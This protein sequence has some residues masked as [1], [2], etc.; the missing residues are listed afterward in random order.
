VQTFTVQ[1]AFK[2]DYPVQKV[3]KA[4]QKL[5]KTP[6]L[7]GWIIDESKS[8]RIIDKIAQAY[9]RQVEMLAPLINKVA[10]DVPKRRMRKLHIGLFGYSRKVGK[11]SL[12]R[13]IGFCA[14]CYSLGLPPEILGFNALDE[15]DIA[16]LKEV[17]IDLNQTMSMALRF[18]NDKVFDILPENLFNYL[19]KAFDM[20]LRVFDGEIDREHEYLTSQIIN[21]VQ[22]N[23]EEL[24]PFIIEAAHLRG[25]LG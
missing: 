22:Y 6:R 16:Y 15:E 24:T 18:F 3:I 4:I 20:A 17:Y 2:Y 14:A 19:K 1:S 10:R 11:I 8:L 21:T 23:K 5:K 12:P 7:Q 9:A 25:F 13:A